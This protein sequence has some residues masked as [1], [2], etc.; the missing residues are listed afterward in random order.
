MQVS[1]YLSAPS[2]LVVCSHKWISRARTADTVR[3]CRRQYQCM[4]PFF[5]DWN[6]ILSDFN[7]FSLI[8][9]DFVCSDCDL[10][11]LD[12]TRSS[13]TGYLTRMKFWK[14]CNAWQCHKVNLKIWCLNCSIVTFCLFHSMIN[15]YGL[16]NLMLKSSQQFF[17]ETCKDIIHFRLLFIIMIT[18]VSLVAVKRCSMLHLFVRWS[19][20]ATKSTDI[21]KIQAERNNKLFSFNWWYLLLNC[22]WYTKRQAEKEP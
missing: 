19:L 5:Q 11:I 4:I 18:S 15:R 20:I 2:W 6:L 21:I 14:K 3:L 1:V 13:V 7:D 17:I 9:H 10:F 22:R 16:M 12:Y 8:K